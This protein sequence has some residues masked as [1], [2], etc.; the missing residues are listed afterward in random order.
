MLVQ[1]VVE[2]E[3]RKERERERKRERKQV[4]FFVFSSLEQAGAAKAK[5]RDV[6]ALFFLLT[7]NSRTLPVT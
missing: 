1:D 7:R 6:V 4:R 2:R 5:S 3:G